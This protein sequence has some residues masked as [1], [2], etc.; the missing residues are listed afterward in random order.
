M[1]DDPIDRFLLE[2]LRSDSD[3]LTARAAAHF[4][5]TRQAAARRVAKLCE[6]GVVL[7]SGVGRGRRYK[8]ATLTANAKTYPLRG[9]SEDTVWSESVAP[10]LRELSGNVRGTWQYAVTE[11]VNN[12]IDH[13]GGDTVAI[14]VH[15]TA[16][17]TSVTIEDDGIGIFKKIAD[18]LHLTDLR[19]AI[20]ELAKGKFTTDPAHHSGE[21]LF[22]TSKA[23][24]YFSLAAN[25]LVFVHLDGAKGDSTAEVLLSE[26]AQASSSAP[27]TCG[28]KVSMS[29]ANS[30]SRVLQAIFD[31]FAEP[32][33]FTFTKT[34]VP[35]KL[36]QYEGDRL[37]SRSQAKRLTSRFEN[38][39]HVILDFDGV[40]EIGQAFADEVFRVFQAR[41]PATALA[42]IRM[43]QAVEKMVRRAQGHVTAAVSQR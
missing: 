21:G 39:R 27:V 5:I 7:A 24:G 10:R 15:Q 33:E 18:A 20:L 19:Q 23:L 38:F 42:P 1:I 16:I 22:F 40:E 9:L 4:H 14:E 8:L 11:L 35:V 32:D 26:P 31:K 41:Y 13:S 34:L 30:S 2:S 28:T 36:A 29:M 25:G 3:R 12:A 6:Q 17:D 37:V 43:T